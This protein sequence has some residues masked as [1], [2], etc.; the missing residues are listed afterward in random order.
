MALTTTHDV[1][2]VGA[3]PAGCVAGIVLARAGARV[4][5]FDRARFPRHKLCGDSINPGTLALLARL[6]LG[7]LPEGEGLA[8]DG[9][10]V[11]GEGGARVEAPYPRHVTGRTLARRELD[12][13]LL[14]RALEAGVQVEECVRVLGPLVSP[15]PSRMPH[16]AGVR[17][18]MPNGAAFDLAS[19]L[20]I[21]ADGR[22]SV[23]AFALGLARHPRRPRRWAVG[24]YFEGVDGLSSFGEMHV[25]A[26]HYFGVAPLPGGLVNACL[27]TP[28]L[29]SLSSY[30]D[31]GTLLTAAIGADRDL[32]PRFAS[33]RLVSSPTALGPLAV[34]ARAAGMPG[35]LLAG[36]A[37]GFVDPMTGDGLRFAI[38]GGEL[39]AEAALAA[40]A[41]GGQPPYARL[42][43]RRRRAFARKQRLNRLVRHLVAHPGS[44][45]AASLV[46]PLWPAAVR[47]LVA[48]AGDV[49]NAEP[50][51]TAALR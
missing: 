6:G 2:I 43:G 30:R 40:L 21:A 28:D 38:R 23:L 51:E 5:M 3:G 26:G 17:L 7:A 20:T 13:W 10:I 12:A 36:D 8:I 4:L 48:V 31:L 25:R 47:M 11:T 45:R 27:V 22:R 46:A 16:V 15:G 9:M 32:A 39:A 33:A 18:R 24:G 50:A 34:D 41:A 14:E 44:V 19:P 42:A 35:L 49:R 29:R 37:A 1:L